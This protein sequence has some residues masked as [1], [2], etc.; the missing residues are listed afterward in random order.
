M[1]LLRIAALVAAQYALLVANTRFI[2]LHSYL[3]TISTDAVIVM[4]GF[5]L[6]KFVVQAETWQEKL[7]YLLGGCCGSAFALWL[8]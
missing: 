6:T 4:N 7:A 2:A 1:K 5:V 8:T 3:G